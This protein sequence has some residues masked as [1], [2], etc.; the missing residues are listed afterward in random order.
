MNVKTNPEKKKK[1][2]IKTKIS[3]DETFWSILGSVAQSKKIKKMKFL[4]FCEMSKNC[5]EIF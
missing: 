2:K 5:F 1:S 4:N 3:S